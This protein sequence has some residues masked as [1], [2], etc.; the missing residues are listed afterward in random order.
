MGGFDRSVVDHAFFPD[1]RWVSQ[2]LVN[3]GFADDTKTPP[4]LP[5]LSADE[6]LR[7]A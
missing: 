3:I 4:R 6:V 5:R 7:F 1:G 2:Y